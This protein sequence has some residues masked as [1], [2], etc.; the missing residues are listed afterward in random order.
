MQFNFNIYAAIILIVSAAI[1]F[2]GG[3]IAGKITSDEKKIVN[4]KIVFKSVAMLGIIAA[5]LIS[6]YFN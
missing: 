4:L 3:F 6:I 2:G 5:L 1:G